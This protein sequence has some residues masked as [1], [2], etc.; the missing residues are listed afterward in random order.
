MQR[1]TRRSTSIMGGAAPDTII[2]RADAD[3]AGARPLP[4]VRKRVQM[5]IAASRETVSLI[6]NFATDEFLRK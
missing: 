3:R 5:C 1:R 4:Q 6:C 2:G